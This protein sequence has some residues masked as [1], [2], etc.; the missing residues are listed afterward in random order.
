MKLSSALLILVAVAV[1]FCN[2]GQSIWPSDSDNKKETAEGNI[3]LGNEAKNDKDWET[4]LEYYTRATELDPYLTDGWYLKAEMELRVKGITLPELIGELLNDNED[5]LPFFPDSTLDTIN[6]IKQISYYEPDSGRHVWIDYFELDS[7]YDRLVELFEPSI[8]AYNDLMVIFQG[9]TINGR[10]I[11]ATKGTFTRD[12]ILSDFTMLS[13]LQTALTT[14]DNSPK[15]YRLSPEHGPY[16]K[17]RNLYKILG[18]GLKKIDSIEIDMDAVKQNFDGPDDI[19]DMINDLLEAAEISLSSINEWDAEIKGSESEEIDKEML[20]DPKANIETIILKANYYYYNDGRD[21]DHDYWDTNKD[22]IMHRTIWID[23]NGNDKIDWVNPATG[24]NFCIT[25]TFKIMRDSA[26]YVYDT[27]YFGIT[28]SGEEKYYYFKDTNGGEFVA[29]DWGVDEESLDGTDSTGDNDGDGLKDEDSRIAKDTLDQDG[30]F[31]DID[32][33]A[34]DDSLHGSGKFAK[35]GP[36]SGKNLSMLIWV[37]YNVD[38]RISAP[39]GTPITHQYVLDSIVAITAAINSG[40]GYGE[41]I[42]GDWGV[43]EEY[44]DGIDNDGDGKVDEDGDI[45]LIHRSEYWGRNVASSTRNR[46]MEFLKTNIN[47]NDITK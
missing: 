42:A 28:V 23:T 1:L 35:T 16:N 2:C 8:Q 18:R 44:V 20:D 7:L 38:G 47:L 21:N 40:A 9:D 32:I 41:W 34:F 11:Q 37:D 43:D 19:N 36:D 17:E 3:L 33:L 27:H 25:D 26:T 29:G 31:I 22:G 15:D 5:K 14:L 13:S 24:E 12:K 10:F 6:P 46:Y 45:H 30:D 4:A 39:D